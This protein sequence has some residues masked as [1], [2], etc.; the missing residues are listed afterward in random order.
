M[1]GSPK[2]SLASLQKLQNRAL[3]ICMCANRY[4]SNLKLHVDTNVLPLYL[5][6]KLEIY[7]EMYRRMLHAESSREADHTQSQSLDVNRATTRYSASRPP[8]FTRPNCVKFLNSVTYQGP[9]LWANL[10]AQMKNLND[11]SKFSSE[12]KNLVNDELQTIRFL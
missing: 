2:A 12:V 10:P 7:N 1:L 9:K 11:M 4:M 5:R 3:R 6:R 8:T